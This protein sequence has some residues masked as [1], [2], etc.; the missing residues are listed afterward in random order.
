MAKKLKVAILGTGMVA[1]AAHIPAW[2]NL[3]AAGVEIVAASDILEDRAK[4]VARTYGIPQ[5]FGNWKKMLAS[6]KPDIVSICTPNAYHKEQT[7]AA[8]K[9]GAH[10]LC[11]KPAATSE[12]DAAEMFDAAERA[13]RLLLIGQSERFSPRSRAAKEIVEAGRLGEIYFAETFYLRR[14]G[15]PKWGQFHIMEHSGGGPVYDLGVHA[16][17]LLFWL[18]GGPKI[19]AV[20]GATYRKFGHLDE[21]LATSLADAGA[22]LGVLTPRPF[23]PADFDVE[24]MAAAL[25]RLEGGATIAFKTSWALNLTENAGRTAIFGTGGGLAFDPLTLSTTMGG[26]TVNVTPQVPAARAVVFAG[27]WEETAHFVDV[28][29]GKADLLVKRQEVLRVMA[30][31]D[32][33]YESAARGCEVKVNQ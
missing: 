16:I 3:K 20:S 14:R 5:A 7:I 31:L 18:M 23:N 6:A 11:E 1:T 29:R 21:G 10:V 19:V 26:Y 22:P 30:T 32:A 27:H 12:A 8:L 4:L 2:Q 15:V 24:D 17:D 13:G 25:I 9:A 33:M 28:I